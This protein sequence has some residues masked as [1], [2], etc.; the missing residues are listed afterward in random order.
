[1]RA[2]ERLVRVRTSFVN[3]SRDHRLRVHLPL[4]SLAERSMAESAFEVEIRGLHAEGRP[5]E[6]ALPT[7]PARRFVSAGGLTVVH[8][9]VVEYELIDLRQ[10]PDG[11]RAAELALTVLRST[12]MLSRLGMTYRPL[13]A[14]PLTPVEGL[15]LLGQD[16]E[17]RYGL[18]M[19]EV[20]PWALADDFL[21]PLDVV[22]AW[23]GGE[24]SASGSALE[25]TGA[26]VSAVRREGSMIEVRLYNPGPATT[27]VRFAA[28][29]TGW[30]VDLRGRPMTT[31]T[32]SFELRAF[33]IATV[34][35]P[36]H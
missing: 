3:P 22:H 31:F 32:E 20:D 7:F 4:P 11:E 28:G 23:G 5:E 25:V 18:A 17:L 30:L 36:E 15:Q 33:G 14:G 10:T 19:G 9:G 6:R 29:T 34:H 26:E 35:M 24:R 13:P 12:G 8:D 16:I 2:D 21:L 27:T 1:M